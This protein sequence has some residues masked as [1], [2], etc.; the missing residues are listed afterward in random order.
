MGLGA[1]ASGGKAMAGSQL[2][3]KDK[4]S[5]PAAEGKEGCGA[6]PLPTPPT[7]DGRKPFA[8]R[9]APEKLGQ[10]IMV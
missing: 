8:A 5:P 7:P 3:I 4:I 2:S 6:P 10:A 1:W 9:L